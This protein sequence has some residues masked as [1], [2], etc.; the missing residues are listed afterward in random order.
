MASPKKVGI[1]EIPFYAGRLKSLFAYVLLE[2]IMHFP[3]AKKNTFYTSKRRRDI[4]KLSCHLGKVREVNSF[5]PPPMENV[6]VLP[7]GVK[8]GI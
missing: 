1:G 2:I 8:T 4:E 5:T 6:L 3:S 7:G